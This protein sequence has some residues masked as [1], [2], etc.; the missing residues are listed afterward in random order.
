[1]L[2]L[3]PVAA[4]LK[5]SAKLIGT[6]EAL[7]GHRSAAPPAPVED[8]T[9]PVGDRAEPVGERAKPVGYRAKHRADAPR[10]VAPPPTLRVIA[11]VER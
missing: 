1:V 9:Q 7:L 11:E 2:P 5:D 3:L 8:R 6:A 10:L 4:V